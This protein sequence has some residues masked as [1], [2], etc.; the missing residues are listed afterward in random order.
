MEAL[1]SFLKLREVSVQL[2][3]LFKKSLGEVSVI[4]PSI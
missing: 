2:K 4:Y 1:D 3:K